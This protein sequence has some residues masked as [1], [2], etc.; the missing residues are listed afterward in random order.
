[1]EK[2]PLKIYQVLAKIMKKESWRSVL[3]PFVIMPK[4]NFQNVSDAIRQTRET[5]YTDAHISLPLVY[6]S[7]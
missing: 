3:T 1:M 2:I 4:M 6:F 7:T 5:N